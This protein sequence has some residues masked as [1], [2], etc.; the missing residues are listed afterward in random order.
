MTKFVV[1]VTVDKG[2]TTCN[3]VSVIVDPGDSVR[4]TCEDGDLAVEFKNSPF[5]STQ[6]WTAARDQLTPV[7]IV[8]PNLPHGTRFQ[9]T[10]SILEKEV[11]E[12]LGDL[13]VR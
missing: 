3:P 6:I 13:I 4:W 12:S 2:K 8:K 10:I 11:A 1:T 9:P 5:T 7:A